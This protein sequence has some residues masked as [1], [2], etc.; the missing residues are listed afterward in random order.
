MLTFSVIVTTFDRPGLLTEALGSVFRQTVRDLEI[1]VVD[2]AGSVP[3]RV[4]DDPRVRLVRR[5]R[6]GGPAAARNT[7]IEHARG[8]FICFLDDDDLYTPDRLEVVAPHLDRAPLVLV[9]ARYLDGPA[10]PG[11]LLEGDVHNVILDTTTPHLGT[12][13]I[14]RDAIV[15]FDETYFAS[16]DLEWWLRQSRVSRVTTIPSFSYLVRR[17]EGPREG[18]GTQARIDHQ[19]RLLAQYH[20]YFAEHPRARAFRWRRIGLMRLALGNYA[21]ARAAFAAS[22][23]A[24]PHARTAW[25]FLRA[26]RRGRA[27]VG[28]GAGKE[29]GARTR[30]AAPGL[31]GP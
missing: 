23:A 5:A 26:V 22:F 8:R 17:H 21:G 9:W 3:A 30:W 15:P 2:D 25:H 6:R 7:G 14:H 10:N 31:P 4:P 28:G 18:W 16:E 20:G 29:E 19:L 13:T 24:R 12:V 1:V 27:G 11:R